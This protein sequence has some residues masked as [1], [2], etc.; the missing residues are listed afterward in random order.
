MGF[1][2]NAGHKFGSATATLNIHAWPNAV[3]RPELRYDRS[4][5]AA[6]DARKDQVSVALGLAY[7]Y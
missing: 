3:L 4:T 5:L 1:P 7:L 2:V 6:F